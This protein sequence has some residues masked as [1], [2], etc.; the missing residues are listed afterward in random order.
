M[1]MKRLFFILG[2]YAIMLSGC[3]EIPENNDPI[4]GVWTKTETNSVSEK[5]TGTTITEE[6]TFNDVFLG[7]YE[8]FSGNTIVISRDFK[9]EVNNGVYKM[10]YPQDNNPIFLTMDLPELLTQNGETFA[11][12]K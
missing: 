11:I 2:I 3:S 7:R 8:Q 9:W 5:T 4:L 12:K 6:W 10:Y 1:L